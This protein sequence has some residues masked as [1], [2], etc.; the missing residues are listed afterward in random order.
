MNDTE[1]FNEYVDGL[2]FICGRDTKIKGIDHSYML[3]DKIFIRN[4]FTLC[5]WAGG[6]KVP[7]TRIAFKFY[8]NVINLV[9]NLCT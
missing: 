1:V 7:N 2:S 5:L 9:L 3:V 6:A 8:E 4:F